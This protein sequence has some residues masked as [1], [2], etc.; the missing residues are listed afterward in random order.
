[1]TVYCPVE[2]RGAAP[3]RWVPP[4]AGPVLST[5]YFRVYEDVDY[6]ELAR[7]AINAS[8]LPPGSYECRVEEI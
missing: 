1:M 4:G 2:A 8:G 5:V 6:D 3:G 7:A